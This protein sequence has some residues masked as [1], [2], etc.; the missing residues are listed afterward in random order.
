MLR[1]ISH[2]SLILFMSKTQRASTG[3]VNSVRQGKRVNL[4]FYKSYQIALD[5]FIGIA[6]RLIVRTS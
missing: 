5:L 6:G 2:V 1:P 4:E 3:G